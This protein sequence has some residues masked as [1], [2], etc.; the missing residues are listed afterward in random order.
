[1][2]PS[3]CGEKYYRS[4]EL[5]AILGGLMFPSPC[6]EKYYRSKKGES[7]GYD[8][9]VFVSIPLRG[10]VLQKV[11]Q[12]SIGT[13]YAKNSFPSPC[14]EKYYRRPLKRRLAQYGFQRANPR[15]PSVGAKTSDETKEISI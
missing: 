9:V 8:G 7:V 15:T 6:G 2:F 10:K 3:P 5:N 1:M 14:G 11:F 4:P 13:P 12:F